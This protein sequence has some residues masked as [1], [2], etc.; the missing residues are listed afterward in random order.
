[1]KKILIL[2]AILFLS[3]S[4]FAQDL[5]DYT[6]GARENTNPIFYKQS[7][8]FVIL[9]PILPIELKP[10]IEIPSKELFYHKCEVGILIRLQLLPSTIRIK[11]FD[12]PFLVGEIFKNTLLPLEEL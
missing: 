11:F 9:Y 2:L 8:E 1:M 10:S 12:K 6:L 3:T 7:I 5:S 4:L